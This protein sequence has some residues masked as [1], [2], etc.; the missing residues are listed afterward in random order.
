MQSS[1][2]QY[3]AEEEPRSAILDEQ[4]LRSESEQYPEMQE[5]GPPQHPTTSGAASSP[6]TQ[7]IPRDEGPSS[8]EHK[9][10]SKDDEFDLPGHQVVEDDQ[11]QPEAGLHPVDVMPV[12]SP[13]NS[14]VFIRS[15][16]E[17]RWYPEGKLKGIL[18]VEYD[19]PNKTFQL[20]RKSDL[21]GT[22][23]SAFILGCTLTKP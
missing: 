5:M 16:G 17:R 13:A 23:N 8:I 3:H 14:L 22:C 11:P 1:H 12:R 9:L 4:G 10:G 2:N 21:R 18:I 15:Y 20:L 19:P 7:V 6:K